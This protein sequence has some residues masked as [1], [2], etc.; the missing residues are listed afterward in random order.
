MPKEVLKPM[1]VYAD[2]RASFEV[3]AYCRGHKFAPEAVAL[4]RSLRAIEAA[5]QKV[6][7]AEAALEATE[8]HFTNCHEAARIRMENDRHA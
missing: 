5:R 6:R 3:G 7:E 2:M 8:Q 1:D 4:A